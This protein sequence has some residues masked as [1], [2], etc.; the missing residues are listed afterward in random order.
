MPDRYLKIILTVI[1]LE[2]LW[3]GAQHSATPV[4][5]QATATP[6]IIT[7]IQLPPSDAAFLP[8]GVIGSYTRIPRAAAAVVGPLA[9]RVNGAVDVTQPL[10]IE[11]D[12]PLLVQQ[13]DYTP[14]ARPG[15]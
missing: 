2:L 1:A 15:E 14:R 12:R 9:V 6:V 7:G 10:K 8:V 13:V 5:A 4:S 3:I 11:A